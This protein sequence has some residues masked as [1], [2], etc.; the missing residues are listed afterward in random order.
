ME[1]TEIKIL[2]FHLPQ[3]HTFPENDGWWGKGFTEWTNVKRAKPLYKNH[4]QPRIPEN[5]DYYDLKDVQVIKRQT[6][7]AKKY[8]IYGFCYYH[9]W[10]DG[11]LLLNE[12]LEKMLSL[13]EKDKIEYCFCW[14]NE[15]WTRAW[16]GSTEVLMPQ[17][18]G[19]QDDW[20]EH[21][22]YLLQFFKDTK[23]IKIDNRP[24]L[25]LYRTNN[26][27]NCDDMISYWDRKCK[28]EGMKGIYIIE[29]KNNFQQESAC[30]L[31]SAIL[32]FEPMYTLKHG[33]SFPR[34]I[35]DRLYAN[36]DNLINKNNLLLYKYNKVWKSIITRQHS[37]ADGKKEFLGAF[38]DW[39]NTPRKGKNG[40]VIRG[41]TPE[42]FRYYLGLQMERAR[43]LQSDFLFINAWNEWGEGTYLEPD[44][45][46]KYEYL[47]SI[48]ECLKG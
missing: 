19:S 46:F 48:K 2:A 24:I 43:R 23:Y 11:K 8:G 30:E 25:I 3:F 10:F 4:N 39:D 21:F 32:E 44:E 42:K 31:S 45:S 33:R 28:E 26:I 7:L 6:Q 34:R 16:E 41:A 14:A 5:R 36:I 12:P 22:Q 40:L 37:S 13:E 38:V 20:R 35:M 18:Y 15:P 9:Y 17:N 27:P 47:E 1:E 29:E